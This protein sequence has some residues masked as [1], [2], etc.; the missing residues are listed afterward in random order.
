LHNHNSHPA[1]PR[2]DGNAAQVEEIIEAKATLD[3]TL[4]PESENGCLHMV[5]NGKANFYCGRIF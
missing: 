2:T 5:A 1:H 4:I 3:R